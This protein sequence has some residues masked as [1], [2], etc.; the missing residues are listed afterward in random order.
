MNR[1]IELALKT[2]YPE[3]YPLHYEQL[4]P[5]MGLFGETGEW[6][7]KHKKGLFKPGVDLDRETELD[8][9]GDISYYYRIL[10]YQTQTYLQNDTMI[11]QDWHIGNIRSNMA[12]HAG[13]IYYA[14][15]MGDIIKPVH[16]L[17]FK[18]AM[19][20]RLY[21]LNITWDELMDL[22][23]QKLKPGSVRGDQWRKAFDIKEVK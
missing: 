2:W 12:L 3:D 20:T 14:V 5:A 23:W 9:L 19:N 6:I 17:A 11:Q 13:R 1:G 7:N 4:H 8:E 10:V 18:I 15:E 22:N 16:L 21:Q